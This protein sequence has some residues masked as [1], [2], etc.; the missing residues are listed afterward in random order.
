MDVLQAIRTR[1]FVLR[2]QVRRP[3]LG[4]AGAV[5]IARTAIGRQARSSLRALLF[6]V[7]RDK[8]HAT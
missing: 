5:V 6:P 8:S 7:A 4:H 2:Q 3:S 1:R